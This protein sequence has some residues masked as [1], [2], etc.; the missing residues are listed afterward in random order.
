[1]AK[2]RWKIVS[3]RVDAMIAQAKR[4]KAVPLPSAL[5]KMAA[6]LDDEQRE[7]FESYL[8][9]KLEEDDPEDGQPRVPLNPRLKAQYLAF[10][11]PPPTGTAANPL[12][13]V[14]LQKREQEVSPTPKTVFIWNVALTRFKTLAC[15]GADLPVREVTRQHLVKFK[16]ALIKLPSLKGG[17]LSAT[18]AKKYPDA[19]KSTLA[20][21]LSQGWLDANPA[22]GLSIRGV[23][24][25]GKS[26]RLPYETDEARA[27]LDAAA[28]LDE[29]PNRYLP[30]ILAY[31][32]MRLSE[33]GGLRSGDVKKLDNTWVFSVEDSEVRRV[34]T[35]SSRRLV[36]IHSKLI[37]AGL[38]DYAERQRA[39]GRDRL[40]H[41]LRAGTSSLNTVTTS[42]GKWYSRWARRF[43][44]D[45]RKVAHSWRHTVATKLRQANVRE[46]LMDELLGWSRASMNARSGSGFTVAMK[47]DA[48]EAIAY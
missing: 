4:G 42:W 26:A 45:R 21:A 39:A 20:Y 8:T 18:S 6:G 34:K 12:L 32:G 29:G 11:N 44:P 27:L 7:A 14:V 35:A 1:L 33:A 15:D 24:G 19:V 10:L 3:A 25:G 37:D 17:T 5:A 31:S 23:N 47:K 48:I 13:S 28:T 41:T 36:P 38:L 9:T 16:D 40:F 2:L 22:T 43:V 46:D 30:V